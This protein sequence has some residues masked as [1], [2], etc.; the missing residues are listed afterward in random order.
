MQPAHFAEPETEV[1]VMYY[2]RKSQITNLSKR[3]KSQSKSHLTNPGLTMHRGAFCQFPFRW[4]YYYGS[5][6]S[7][8]KETGKTHLCALYCAKV[9]SI[10]DPTLIAQILCH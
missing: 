10:I 1:N 6:K 2:V 9:V 4:I 8:G 5:N 3:N 7:T